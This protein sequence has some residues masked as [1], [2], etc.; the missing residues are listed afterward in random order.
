MMKKM[1]AMVSAIVAAGVIL[2]ACVGR[3]PIPG[4]TDAPTTYWVQHELD[5]YAQAVLDSDVDGMYN[6]MPTVEK[7]R[8]FR[9]VWSSCT[10]DELSVIADYGGLASFRL[11]ATSIY[12]DDG[13]WYVALRGEFSSEAFGDV[14]DFLTATL[15]QEA[16]GTWKVGQVVDPD[17]DR[18]Y[19][20]SLAVDN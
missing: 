14:T 2:S 9:G 12:E 13:Q 16:D 1:I 20:M 7:D 5:K 6:T 15:E 19:V 3:P 18:C 4:A 11:E 8:I 17:P 10:A